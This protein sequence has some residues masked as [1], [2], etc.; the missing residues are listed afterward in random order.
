MKRLAL[1]AALLAPFT[2]LPA[3]DGNR[4]NQGEVA[5]NASGAVEGEDS[6]ES[7]PAETGGERQDDA[8]DSAD[9]AREAQADALEEQAEAVDAQADEQREA[10][11]EQA[12]QVRNR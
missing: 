10:L 1:D 11:E 7:G 4:E 8:A 9:D 12:D 6:I 5:D 2:L 3:C